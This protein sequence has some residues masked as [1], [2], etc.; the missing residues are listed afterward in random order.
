[1]L[2]N[3]SFDADRNDLNDFDVWQRD[4]MSNQ[5]LQINWAF[6][7]FSFSVSPFRVFYN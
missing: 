6:G 7:S 5:V 1:M 3:Q 4:R 2:L